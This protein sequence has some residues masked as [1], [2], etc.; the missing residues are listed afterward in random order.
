MLYDTTPVIVKLTQ[1]QYDNLDQADKLNGT[2]YMLTDAGSI[3]S[4]GVVYGGGGG[5]LIANQT[6]VTLTTYTSESL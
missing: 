4:N 2:I 1:Q 6:F 3:M 5:G